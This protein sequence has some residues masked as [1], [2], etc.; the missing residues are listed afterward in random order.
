MTILPSQSRHEVREKQ[1]LRKLANR[2]E[3]HYN[4]RN[5][6]YRVST[7]VNGGTREVVVYPWILFRNFK[8]DDIFVAPGLQRWA[9]FPTTSSTTATSSMGG[10]RSAAGVFATQQ[11]AASQ[12]DTVR[13]PRLCWMP[14]N[15][16]V[17]ESSIYFRS[18]YLC[19][20]GIVYGL[21]LRFP[22][23]ENIVL[24]EMLKWRGACMSKNDSFLGH[25][26][27]GWFIRIF[28]QQWMRN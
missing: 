7:V 3:I 17:A 16:E 1:L 26:T 28:W 22:R 6:E 2:K 21:V 14:K 5:E 15:K 10:S 4:L 13:A 12:A 20:E 24:G 25:T 23:D 9:A 19:Y 11:S 27:P 18:L 8:N